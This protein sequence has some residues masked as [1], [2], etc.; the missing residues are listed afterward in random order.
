MGNSN[1][2]GPVVSPAGFTGDVTGDITG[3]ITGNITGN[4]TGNVTGDVTGN[5]TGD[6]SGGSIAA[7]TITASTSVAIGT[8]GTV[9]TRVLKGTVSA[10]VSALAAAAEEDV[11]VAFAN[12]A[13]GDVV[14]VTPLEATAETGLTWHAW[15]LS[16]GNLTLRFGNA[17]GSSLTGSTSNWSVL[18]Y[19]S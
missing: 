15:V 14:V 16:A 3:D 6:Q 7:T 11:D 9:I 13:A 19:Q 4:V 17:S 10:T 12:A 1:F 2:S 8:S 5:V 18:I